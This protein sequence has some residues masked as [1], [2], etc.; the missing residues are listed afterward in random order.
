MSS[1]AIV[2]F[3]VSIYQFFNEKNYFFCP[4]ALAS[5]MSQCQWISN[6]KHIVVFFSTCP[7]NT[8]L[9]NHSFK[10]DSKK[11]INTFLW[12]SLSCTNYSLSVQNILWLIVTNPVSTVKHQLL[13]SAHMER[14]SVLCFDVTVPTAHKI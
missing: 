4:E 12:T 14:C 11:R 13:L 2:F 6:S 5:T 9:T 8:L 3:I 1:L 10:P 7:V